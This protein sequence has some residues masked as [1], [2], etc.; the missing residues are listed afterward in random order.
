MKT[1]NVNEL[2]KRYGI[3]GQFEKTDEEYYSVVNAVKESVKRDFKEKPIILIS[4]P[5]GSGKTTT[6]EMLESMLDVEGVST[7]TVSIDNYFRTVTEAERGNVDYESPTRVDGELLSE[8]IE[9]IARCEEVEIPIFDFVSTMRSDKTVRLKRKPDELVIFEGIHALN[10]SVITAP[11]DTTS[12]IYISVRTR[13]SYGDKLLPPEYVRLMRRIARD[14]LFRGRSA[15]ETLKFYDEVK[16]GE[17]KYV[18][19]FKRYADYSIDSFIGYE[20]GVYKSVVESD[21][22]A[23]A[24]NYET[25][26]VLCEFLK[27][28]KPLDPEKTPYNSLIREF[29]GR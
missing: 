21:V 5:S 26:K 10:P 9:K 18:L 2:N 28:V 22:S 3:P 1:V 19:P 13:V 20:V 6:A 14:K 27:N 12:K 24:G 16:R 15:E 8:H 25:A 4:G 23:L 29:I 17:D 11:K 7:H